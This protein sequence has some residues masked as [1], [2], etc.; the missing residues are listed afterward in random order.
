MVDEEKTPEQTPEDGKSEQ[1]QPVKQESKVE[2]TEEVD[3]QGVSYK[4]RYAES[5]RKRQQL[6]ESVEEMTLRM[7]NLEQ[8]FQSAPVQQP[9]SNQTSKSDMDEMIALGPKAYNEK[10]QKD[11]QHKQKLIDAENLIKEKYGAAR[12]QFGVAKILDYAQKNL[13]DINTDPVRAVSK[14][15][16]DMEKPK[17]KPSVEDRK[18]TAEA[19]K[20]KPEGGKRPP[21]PPVN[22]SSELM[23]N[24]YERGSI[25]DVAAALAEQWKQNNQK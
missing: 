11:F 20:N 12:L 5:E 16:S 2:A 4:N 6:E 7:N 23:K 21:A 17:V 24:V 9:V 3:E 15:L 1:T 18:K 13:I 8:K 14:I 22:N 19:I 25:E 10:L